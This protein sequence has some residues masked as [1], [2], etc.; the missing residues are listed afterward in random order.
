MRGLAVAFL[1]VAG[2]GGVFGD[3]AL[4]DDSDAGSDASVSAD[5]GGSCARFASRVCTDGDSY[6][7]DSCGAGGELAESCTGDRP[8]LDTLGRCCQPAVTGDY[9]GFQ[10][11]VVIAFELSE[12]PT[13]AGVAVESQR[14][15]LGRGS[16]IQY[17]G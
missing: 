1:L 11:G 13:A 17:T 12:S 6:W 3:S 15:S 2:C 9:M 4:G 14:A 5:D 10:D 16:L 8:C 7:V